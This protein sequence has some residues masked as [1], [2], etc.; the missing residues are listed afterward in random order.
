MSHLT[1]T[2]AEWAAHNAMLNAARERSPSQLRADMRT[3]AAQSPQQRMFAKGRLKAGELN[4]TEQAYHDYL[5]AKLYAGQLLWFKFEA[6]NL[7]LADNTFYS[8]D[9][10]VM[11]PD[12][13]LECHEVKGRWMD[14]ARAKIKIAASQF[15]MFRFIAVQ[16]KAA[17]HGGGW[18]IEEF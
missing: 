10:V 16:K 1:M 11:L 13:S 14:D 9:F 3:R 6:F 12:G 5:Q 15:W 18:S 7:R 2:E 4:A 8:P 17:K